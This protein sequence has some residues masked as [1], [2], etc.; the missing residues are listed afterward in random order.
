MAGTGYGQTGCEDVDGCA[1]GPCDDIAE[2][3][4]DL[5]APVEGFVCVCPAGTT[6]VGPN[7]TQCIGSLSD[8][9]NCL[10]I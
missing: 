1:S 6:G 7:N 4:V 5:R 2:E 9:I 8:F 10:K 3:C